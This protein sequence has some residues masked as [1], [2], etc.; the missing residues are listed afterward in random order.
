M[1]Y[2]WDNCIVERL[3]KWKKDWNNEQ[4]QTIEAGRK[5]IRPARL[6]GGRDCSTCN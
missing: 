2:C 1:D 5:L 3:S 4:K 6:R